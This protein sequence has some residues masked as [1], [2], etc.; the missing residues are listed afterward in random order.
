MNPQ[1]L[2]VLLNIINN[3]IEELKGLKIAIKDFENKDWKLGNIEY[4]SSK[5]EIYF[6]CEEEK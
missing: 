3:A 1:R 6:H 4:D 5:D 2:F